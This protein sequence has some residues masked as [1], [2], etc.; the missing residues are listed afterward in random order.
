MQRQ[1]RE[2]RRR[3]L[4]SIL[5]NH[6]W[7]TTHSI[8][9]Q[10]AVLLP[11]PCACVWWEIWGRGG[12]VEMLSM[13]D[14]PQRDFPFSYKLEIRRHFL[15]WICFDAVRSRLQWMDRIERRVSIFCES[16]S[17]ELRTEQQVAIYLYNFLDCAMG[18]WATRQRRYV[19]VTR[20]TPFLSRGLSCFKYKKREIYKKTQVLYIAAARW[21]SITHIPGTQRRRLCES[22]R[23][24][25]S[26]E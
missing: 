6:L 14:I 5:V 7:S 25:G 15:N 3:P 21:Y 24:D 1:E 9:L 17:A 13:N 16:L 2:E 23:D 8:S 10:R 4:I 26:T 12:L 22:R 20:M 19:Y 11:L 18:I